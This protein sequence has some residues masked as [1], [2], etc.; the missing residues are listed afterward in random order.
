[1]IKVLYVA[2]CSNIFYCPL[3]RRPRNLFSEMY[4]HV[5]ENMHACRRDR[6]VDCRM[7]EKSMGGID[8]AIGPQPH[9]LT[10]YVRCIHVFETSHEFDLRMG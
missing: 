5:T 7:C 10:G 8:R 6:R 3:R 9:V 1:M 4:F 2:G